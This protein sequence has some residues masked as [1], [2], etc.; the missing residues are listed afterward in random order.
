MC[1]EQKNGT[2]AVRQVCHC[3]YHILMSSVI[4]LL[5]RHMATRNLFVLYNKEVK[6]LTV[7]YTSVLQ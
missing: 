1:Q 7:T 6:K 3:S 2:Q 5:N 4:H